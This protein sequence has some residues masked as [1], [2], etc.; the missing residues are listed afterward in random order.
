MLTSLSAFGLSY[1][2]FSM[3]LM[4]IC[5]PTIPKIGSMGLEGRKRT[6]VCIENRQNLVVAKFLLQDNA[7]HYIRELCGLACSNPVPPGR[8]ISCLAVAQ[9]KQPAHFMLILKTDDCKVESG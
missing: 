6:Q 9:C 7:L 8:V 5:N 4:T 1:H 3:L 2:Y